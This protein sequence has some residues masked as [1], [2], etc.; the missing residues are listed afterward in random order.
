MPGNVQSVVQAGERS[1]PFEVAV[2][3]GLEALTELGIDA[4]LFD[5]GGDPGA[6]KCVLYE[7]GRWLANGCGKGTREAARA[8]AVFESLEHYLSGIR[9]VHPDTVEFRSAHEIANGELRGDGAAAALADGLDQSLACRRYRALTDGATIALP[10]YLACI[11]YPTDEF[12][13]RRHELG[14]TYD[15]STVLRYSVNSG[16]ASGATV[17][18]AT[19]HAL[20]EV[21]ERDAW[22]MLLIRVF[23][24]RQFLFATIDRTSLPEDLATLV[25]CAEQRVGK[26]VELIDMT[27]DLG[28]PSIM[29][30]A[31]PEPGA[32]AVYFGCGTSLS[33]HHATTRALTELIQVKAVETILGEPQCDRD[34]L[35]PYPPFY[36]ASKMDLSDAVGRAK[37]VAYADTKA[38]TTPARHLDR[39]VNALTARGYRPYV[40]ELYVA[41]NHAAVVSVVIPGLERFMIVH[42]GNLVIPGLRGMATIHNGACRA[43]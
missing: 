9:S 43:R 22:S 35:R 5:L 31:A 33:R 26:Q 2:E 14:D 42:L 4:E 39:L 13:A 32:A 1:L 18:E 29:A 19:V 37:R 21:I 23:L 7:R 15:Y 30:Y 27:T 3:R 34:Q 36:E 40:R 11:D 24:A 12:T 6:W 28:V 16:C 10:V 25:T 20:N 41:A 8:G 17:T 38:P